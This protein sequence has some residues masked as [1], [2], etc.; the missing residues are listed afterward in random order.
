MLQRIF[1]TLPI[2][3][4][5]NIVVALQ[6]LFSFFASSEIPRQKPYLQSDSATEKVKIPTNTPLVRERTSMYA[7]TRLM[8]SH[9]PCVWFTLV[10][11]TQICSIPLSRLLRLPSACFHFFNFDGATSSILW[12][13]RKLFLLLDTLKCSALMRNQFLFQWFSF[14]PVWSLALMCKH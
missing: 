1:S 7:P 4:S 6:V 5:R 11:A 9:L 2:R 14:L 13:L 12:F 10:W 3:F 8:V